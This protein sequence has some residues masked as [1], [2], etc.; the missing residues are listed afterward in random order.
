MLAAADASSLNFGTI[1]QKHEGTFCN[2]L[3]NLQNIDIILSSFPGFFHVYFFD[4]RIL[5]RTHKGQSY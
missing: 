1:S 3:Q 4:K 5:H 2:S